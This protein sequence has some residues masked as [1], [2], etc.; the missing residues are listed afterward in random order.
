MLNFF[1]LETSPTHSR[2][3]PSSSG[4]YFCTSAPS[5]FFS[6]KVPVT[7]NFISRS[8]C[9]FRCHA[10]TRSHRRATRRIAPAYPNWGQRLKK[11]RPDL[12]PSSRL[13]Q[14]NLEAVY[15]SFYKSPSFA[16]TIL[17]CTT[18]SRLSHN[19]RAHEVRRCRPPIFRRDA[20]R[21]GLNT[22]RDRCATR[23]I[24]VPGSFSHT[25]IKMPVYTLHWLALHL[26]RLHHLHVACRPTQ[27]LYLPSPQ[28]S[29][30]SRP[31]LDQHHHQVLP[32]I[33][34]RPH[35]HRQLVRTYP[36]PRTH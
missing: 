34:G 3:F 32:C 1:S 23:T 26:R 7:S 31:R 33:R 19:V 13:S 5:T 24:D 2:A 10:H 9:Y 4:S 30:S 6:L 27:R 20:P 12:V 21:R 8:S 35:I 36:H 28:Y 17:V 15:P 25:N 14:T 22:C 29:P 18:P 16:F 11:S